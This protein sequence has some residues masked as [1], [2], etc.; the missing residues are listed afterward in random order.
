MGAVLASRTR[1]AAAQSMAKEKSQAYVA[2]TPIKISAT[3]TIAIGAPV[4]R[5]PAE[6]KQLQECGAIIAADPKTKLEG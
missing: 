3:E 5:P 1:G 2:A 6:M 4:D